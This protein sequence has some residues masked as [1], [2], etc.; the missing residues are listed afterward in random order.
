MIVTSA[1]GKAARIIDFSDDVLGRADAAG[2]VDIAGGV[3]ADADFGFVDV[4]IPLVLARFDHDALVR[5]AANLL[6]AVLAA[7][8]IDAYQPAIGQRLDV[9]GQRAAG[10]AKALGD[11]AHAHR[12]RL[13]EQFHDGNAHIGA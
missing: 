5:G 9:R 13:I 1:S 12:P 2:G 3:L 11:R 4:Q 7:R 6:H 10:D 8:N